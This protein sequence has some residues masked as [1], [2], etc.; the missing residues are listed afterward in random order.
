MKTAQIVS[1]LIATLFLFPHALR[2]QHEVWLNVIVT[3]DLGRPVTD[4]AKADF[5]VKEQDIVHAVTFFSKEEL[6]LSYCVLLDNS[7]SLSEGILDYGREIAKT[8]IN[9]NK[10]ADETCVIRFV[11]SE[12][13]EIVQNFTIN[14]K[15]LFE[16]LGLQFREPGRTA[17]IDAVY[18]ATRHTAQH[19]KEEHGGLRR[20]ALVLITDG[21]D[22][23]SYY[24]ESQL[25][26]LFRKENVQVFVVGMAKRSKKKGGITTPNTTAQTFLTN[27]ARETGGR[28]LF[29]SKA[30]ELANAG[31]DVTL[32]LR[33]QYVIGYTS[34]LKSKKGHRFI[35]VKIAENPGLGKRTVIVRPGYTPASK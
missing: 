5:Q 23:D 28:A 13:V 34:M 7:G 22:I 32:F 1:L 12:T 4:V 17:L 3:D 19:R 16:A 27:L 18:L 29:P 2:A 26:E 21:E 31:N 20:R 35:K 9:S 10:S 6:P 11:G 8:I 24:S 30:A 25:V 33:N 14:Q 15:E